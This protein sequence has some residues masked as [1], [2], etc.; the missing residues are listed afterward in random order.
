MISLPFIIWILIFFLV[1][2]IYD[3]LS[4]SSKIVKNAQLFGLSKKG[5]RIVKK[6]MLILFI[7]MSLTLKIDISQA[8]QIILGVPLVFYFLHDGAYF[9]T[10][11]KNENSTWNFD[12]TAEQLHTHFIKLDFNK[13]AL[14]FSL[15]IIFF[16]ASGFVIG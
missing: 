8:F 7:A 4:D 10:R 6:V 5:Y 3:G 13:R 2:G 14:L 9:Y 11:G 12:S 15:G 16:I 1:M